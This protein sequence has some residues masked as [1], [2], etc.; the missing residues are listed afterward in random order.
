[1]SRMSDAH[2]DLADE[3][4]C[5]LIRNR[6][7]GTDLDADARSVYELLDSLGAD[8]VAP[9]GRSLLAGAPVEQGG[10]A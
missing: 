6:M 7:T 2:V 5:Q 4:R 8:R 10:L 9:V 1:M 3:V